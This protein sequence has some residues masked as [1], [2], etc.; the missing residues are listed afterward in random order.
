MLETLSMMS[1]GDIFY[2]SSYDD[3]KIVF[4]NHS[5]A[6]RKN[7]RA[8][9]GLANSSPSTTSIKNE[10]GNVL[11]DFKSEILH[12]FSL[13][14]DIMQI[15]RKQ[16]EAKRSLAIFYPKC[17]RRH[18]RNECPLNVINICSFYEKNHATNKFPSFLGLKSIYQGAEG[19]AE[20]LFFINQRRHQGPW[21]YEQGIQGVSYSYYK[22]NQNVPLTPW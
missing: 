19:G 9:Q 18:S 17:T 2:Q 11:E 21:P 15:K 5:R 8:S 6:T 1:G 14:M 16:D 13:K 7:G 12:T 22:P 4:K 20:K 3:I 10:I